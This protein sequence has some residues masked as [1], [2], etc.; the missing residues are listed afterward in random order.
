MPETKATVNLPGVTPIRRRFDAPRVEDVPGALA[1]RLA[2]REHAVRAGERIAVAVGSRGI[3]NLVELVAGVVRWIDAR[4][5]EAFLV[6][7]MGSHG[8]ATA[9]GQRD[10]LL[11][12]GLT[13]AAVG[14]PIVSSMETVELPRGRS[15]L[16][17]VVDRNASRADGTILLNRVKPHTSFHGPHESGLMKM[18]AIGLGKQRQ[19]R[20]IHAR[21]VAGL[22]DEM[23]AVARQVLASANIRLGLAV[24]ENALD[25]TMH[26]EA[27]EPADIPR[28]DSELLELARA[29]MP[30]LP[31]DRLDVLI[32][33]EMGKDI[34]GLGMDPNII[35]RLRIR[36]E[37]EPD[38]PDIAVIYV[39]GLTERTHGNA[40]GIG[41]AD[42]TRRAVLDQ[43]DLAATYAN[44]A[45]TTFLQRGMLPL[46]ADD[47]AHA[48]SLAM[49]G[50]G[51]RDPSGLRICRIR[52]TLHPGECLVSPAVLAELEGREDIEILGPARRLLGP[53]GLI[54]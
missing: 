11:G 42:I 23:P 44:L 40:V 20:T 24:V 50:L 6:P 9:A 22:R 41:L 21:G 52:N 48:M 28:R 18:L 46:L 27:V 36:G 32:V 30:A 33:D 13:E 37:A 14:A 19:A 8:G 12:Y 43:I 5:A 4:G 49:D 10:V 47:D 29:H 7:A 17:V 54:D 39:R 45:T 3:A 16:P 35:G 26:V 34:S 53:G 25:E 15:P 1:G 2:A 51:R 38:R 31:V